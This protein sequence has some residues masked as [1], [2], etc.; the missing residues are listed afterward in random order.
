MKKE[1]LKHLSKDELIEI[2]TSDDGLKFRAFN[3]LLNIVNKRLT[4][5]SDK[6][7]KCD[8]T[9]IG[10]YEQYLKLETAYTKWLKILE[11]L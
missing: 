3:T 8:L 9:T 5:I 10:G 1:I 4:D 11:S 6:Q 2:I 7:S